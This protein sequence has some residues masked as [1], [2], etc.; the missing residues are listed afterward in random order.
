MKLPAISILAATVFASAMAEEPK[1]PTKVIEEVTGNAKISRTDADL[2]AISSALKMYKLNAGFYP[3]EEQGLKA[4]VEKP[5]AVPLP[6]RW[7]QVMSA[8]PKDSWGREYRYAVRVK[9]GK[10]ETVI[11]SDGP[12]ADD[13]KDDIEHVVESVEKK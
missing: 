2:H 7:V 1:P 6:K 12:S 9:D 13:K 8:V 5:S 10:K 11:S 4:L 3:T